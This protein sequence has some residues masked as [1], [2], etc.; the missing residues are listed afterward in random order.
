MLRESK[1]KNKNRN[2]SN[3]SGIPVAATHFVHRKKAM[4]ARRKQHV[5]KKPPV[6]TQAGPVSQNKYGARR[7]GD[8]DPPPAPESAPRAAV[9]GGPRGSE[10][11][12]RKGRQGDPPRPRVAPRAAGEGPPAAHHRTSDRFCSPRRQARTRQLRQL[13]AGRE[14]FVLG[15]TPLPAARRRGQ[16]AGP[17]G[18]ARGGPYLPLFGLGKLSCR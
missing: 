4:L 2:R 8:P 12:R 18:V 6:Q 3:T 13:R 17:V 5:G 1:R 7:S 16:E 10:C 9:G 15:Q 14:A 11:E